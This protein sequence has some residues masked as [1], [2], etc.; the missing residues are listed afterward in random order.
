MKRI[1]I[2]TFVFILL[3][4]PFLFAQPSIEWKANFGGS[5]QD[6]SSIITAL[7]DGNYLISGSSGS[8]NGDLTSNNGSWDAWI[9]KISPS[10]SKIWQKSYGGSFLESLASVIETENGDL[11]LLG[12]TGS[13]D[14]DIESGN[15]GGD[16]V[17][18]IRL[19]SQGELIWENTYGGSMNDAGSTVIQTD[20]GGFLVLAESFSEDGDISTNYEN[21]DFLLF[22]V[23]SNGALIWE[24]IFGGSLSDVPTNM[25]IS[26]NNEILLGGLSSSF[27]GDINIS[28]NGL[29]FE[30]VVMKLNIDGDLLWSRTYGGDGGDGLSKILEMDSGGFLLV[31]D[32]YYSEGGDISNSYNGHDCWFLRI[33]ESGDIVWERTYGGNANDIA[34]SVRKRA[35]GNFVIAGASKSSDIDLEENFGDLDCWIFE[36]NENGDFIW[37]KNYG[38]SDIDSA[39]DIELTDDGGAIFTVRSLSIDGEFDM[40][41][42][43]YDF[44]IVKLS[45]LTNTNEIEDQ[46]L[47]AVFPNPSFNGLN[48]TFPK[49]LGEKKI[50]IMNHIGQIVH[51]EKTTGNNIYIE[52]LQ[53]GIYFAQVSKGDKILATEYFS[54]F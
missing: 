18:L 4:I 40:G 2:L 6:R 47:V 52:N 38:G 29:S 39:T 32:M 49:M 20:D 33:N 23:D 45:I 12:K 8:S 34:N 54:V 36:I 43:N 1:I 11:I 41:S 35:N 42:G 26:S 25:I 3:S 46:E 27:D 19:N 21:G 14:G 9:V 16:D 15:N 22:K 48:I 10:G 7:N 53:S 5:E 51:N 44:C 37:G 24:K 28:S 13:D 50:V 17:W 30:Y 31:G